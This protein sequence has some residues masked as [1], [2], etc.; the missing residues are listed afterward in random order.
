MLAQLMLYVCACVSVSILA[1]LIE[2]VSA[3]DSYRLYPF[4]DADERNLF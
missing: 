2:R 3:V 1:T 4:D